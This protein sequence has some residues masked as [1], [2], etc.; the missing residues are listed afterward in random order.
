VVI[1]QIDGGCHG[2]HQKRFG[3]STAYCNRLQ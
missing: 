1:G 2:K 3:E